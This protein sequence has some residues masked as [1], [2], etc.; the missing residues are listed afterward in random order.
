MKQK[1]TV[2]GALKSA[3]EMSKYKE[4]TNNQADT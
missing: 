1:C 4:K 2:Y 3:R